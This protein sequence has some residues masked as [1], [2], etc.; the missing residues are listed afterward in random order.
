MPRAARIFRKAGVNFVPFPVD[1]QVD[2]RSPLTL[3]DFLPR[4]EALARTEAALRELLGIA[5]YALRGA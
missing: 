3:L 5:F 1:Y 4:A 2:P